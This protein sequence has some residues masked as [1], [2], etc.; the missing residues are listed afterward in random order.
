MI[1]TRS[2]EKGMPIIEPYDPSR[3]EAAIFEL[4]QRALGAHW[5]MT[6]ELLRRVIE[7]PGARNAHLV[8]RDGTQAI[9]LAMTQQGQRGNLVAL[10]V[11]SDRQRR[12]IG[13]ALHDAALDQLRRAGAQRVQLGGGETRFWPG[14]PANLPAARSFFEARGWAFTSEVID[15][16]QDLRGYQTPVTLRPSRAVFRVAMPADV[17]EL[18]EFEQREF[19]AWLGAYQVAARFGDTD[20]F[21]LACD[22]RNGAIIGALIIYTPRSH[23]SRTDV[24]WKTLLGDDAGGLG[25]VGIAQAAREYG[26]GT[27][28]VARGSEIARERGVGNCFIGWTGLREFYGRLGYREWQ[29]Y[30]MSR[31]EL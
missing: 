19:P 12:G 27:A 16:T 2:K 5:P 26:A 24:I 30:A 23:T 4:W 29:A 11:D 7:A 20:D 31:R 18:L 13:S 3:D 10:V 25:C 22:P 14:V 28:L 21:L 17:G 9:G 1:D 8:A 6:R 15:L